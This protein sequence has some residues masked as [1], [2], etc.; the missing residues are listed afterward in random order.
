MTG[1]C[2]ERI[3]RENFLLQGQPSYTQHEFVMIA[4][5]GC[6]AFKSTDCRHYLFKI[7]IRT[8]FFFLLVAL[9]LP[10]VGTQELSAQVQI[11]VKTKWLEKK[12]LTAVKSGVIAAIAELPWASCTEFG[13]DY[14]LWLKNLHR[15][16][17]KEGSVIVT[18][19]VEVQAPS[20][21]GNGTL[22][23][24]AKVQVQY[25]LQLLDSIGNL[26]E[27]VASVENTRH[28]YETWNGMIGTA[29]GT[30]IPKA[31]ELIGPIIAE[32]LNN[33]NASPKPEEIYEAVLV[34]TAVAQAMETLFDDLE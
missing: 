26:E 17:G 3:V 4:P 21:F 16:K 14:S 7:M 6:H 27:I 1:V 34:A 12:E 10:L 5:P 2:Q 18:L 8:F 11:D 32:V 20:L 33:V 9:L 23:R 31:K 13:E 15:T 19:E 29:V 24:K 25:D 30:L 22:L 28:Q